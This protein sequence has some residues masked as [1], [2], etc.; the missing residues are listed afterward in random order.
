MTAF[1]RPKRKRTP[2]RPVKV[3]PPAPKPVTVVVEPKL[4][5]N[6]SYV[7]VYAGDSTAFCVK[8][9]RSWETMASFLAGRG[10]HRDEYA[11]IHGSVVKC[12]PAYRDTN[13][14]GWSD[15]QIPNE[16]I[17]QELNQQVID[18]DEVAELARVA[19]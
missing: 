16:D 6:S 1:A 3:R 15:T 10:L 11:I 18:P 8:E 19:L 5:R 7:L 14:G 2:V 17:Q 13:P 9:F 12:T 4:T